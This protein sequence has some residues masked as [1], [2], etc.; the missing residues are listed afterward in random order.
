MDIKKRIQSLR[1]KGALEILFGSFFIKAAGF[2]GS[3]ILARMMTKDSYGQLAYIENR[4]TYAYIFAGLGL[5]NAV[6]RYLVLA[7]N[8]SEK[9][10]V[11]EFVLEA[12]TILNV[13]VIVAACLISSQSSTPQKFIEASKLI[14][15]MLIALP[16]HYAFDVCTY[17]LRALFRNR[18]Y[19]ISAICAVSLIW[20]S[21]IL[22]I[23]CFGLIGAVVSWPVTYGIMSIVLILYFYINDYKGIKKI[24]LSSDRKRE[25]LVYSVQY[26][27]TNGLWAAFHQNDLLMIGLMSGDSAALA[28]YKIAYAI[29]AALSILSTSIGMFVAP[30]F[31]K[32]ESDTK[33]VWTNYKRVVG[34]TLLAVS[35]ISAIL[36]LSSRV[37][38]SSIYGDQ[39]INT[40]PLMNT[41]LISAII[42]NALRYPTANILAAMGNIRVNMTV[43]LIGMIIQI[44]LDAVLIPKFGVYGA[45][46]CSIIVYGLM[47]CSV[48][49]YF[50]I[51]YRNQSRTNI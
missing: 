1:E 40:I 51:R 38:I 20:L 12:G 36:M 34:I 10:A 27:I 39:Y 5:N 33:W 49:S 8:N 45:A 31:V 18:L 15:I 11:Y 41:L 26:M 28:E 32:N 21:K 16:F 50:S 9:R 30:Y 7:K 43:S 3:I 17:S 48:I 29:P 24:N 23:S 2:L 13:F 14:P 19:V 37:V 6:F 42:N 47:A 25:M 44:V 22:G 4:Y 35:T 46:Y